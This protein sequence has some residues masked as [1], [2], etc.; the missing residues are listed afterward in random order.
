[1]GFI[2]FVLFFEIF[3]LFL[4]CSPPPR[5][6]TS[7]CDLRHSS[8]PPPFL[9]PLPLKLTSCFPLKIMI[10]PLYFLKNGTCSLLVF[11]I[12]HNNFIT[13][14][15]KKVEQCLDQVTMGIKSW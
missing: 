3:F 9:L 5:S 13:N 7:V 2:C 12:S 11:L 8:L 15:G 4:F 14:D 10:L 6:P 1:M